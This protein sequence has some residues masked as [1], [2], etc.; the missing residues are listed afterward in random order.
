MEIYRTTGGGKLS[1][2]ERLIRV[3]REIEK[4]DRDILYKVEVIR[5]HKG[6]LIIILSDDIHIGYDGYVLHV[7]SKIWSEENECTVEVIVKG[8][9]DES[10]SICI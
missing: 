10:I 8:R 6:L 2:D 3:V 9:E 1:Y 5:D 7:C 4:V